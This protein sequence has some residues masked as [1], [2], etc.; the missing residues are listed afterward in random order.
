MTESA[1]HVDAALTLNLGLTCEAL[2]I[3]VFGGELAVF[4]F[5]DCLVLL[6]LEF[7]VD[8]VDA[9]STEVDA[10]VVFVVVLVF[11]CLL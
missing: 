3:V 9:D 4:L 5:L 8:V 11:R 2:S 6:E 7:D 10:A 1:V